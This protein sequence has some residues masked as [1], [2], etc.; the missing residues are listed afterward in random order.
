MPFG[1]PTVQNRSGEILGSAFQN[2]IANYLGRKQQKRQEGIQDEE[3]AQGKSLF[4]YSHPGFH[5][6][7]PSDVLPAQERQD[8]QVKP[9]LQQTQS[10]EQPSVFQKI[11][12]PA[13]QPAF[14]PALGDQRYRYGNGYYVDRG[15]EDEDLARKTATA[16]AGEFQKA[17]LTAMG[18]AQGNP[19]AVEYN[20]ARA[21]KLNYDLSHPKPMA[22][23]LGTPEYL[24]AETDLEK[25]RAGLRPAPS[26]FT[27]L[28][29]TDAEGKPVTVRGNT[30][31]G[32]VSRTDIGRPATG[33]A[34]ER[35]AAQ[36]A[37]AQNQVAEAD[38]IMSAF[39]DRLLR[40]E[41]TISASGAAAAKLAL[42]GGAVMSTTAETA[43]NKLDPDLA[44][45]VR[46]AKA[47]SAAERLIT[48]RGG[49]NALMHAE[50]MLAGAGPH[51][52]ADLV[53]QAREY[54]KALVRGLMT[55][56][57]PAE[58]AA[59][60]PGAFDDLIPKKP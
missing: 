13:L 44:A 9:D 37:V 35:E 20:K 59:S 8:F 6:T 1:S 45:Y 16:G 10:F 55:H 42:G 49:S 29:G 41:R 32:E 15:E 51:A 14:N 28:P 34:G 47:V 22:P 60:Q 52:N 21:A 3:R 54:R 5:F 33:Q 24:R 53:K 39:E 12:G 56:G 27:F 7:S 50:G 30:K 19:S 17:L 25:M 40:G 18:T 4:E 46:A 26:Q 38:K 57:K 48:P 58:A 43:L 2:A 11:L 23:V 36:I 31:T